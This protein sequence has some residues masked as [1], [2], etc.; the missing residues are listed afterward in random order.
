MNAGAGRY[1]ALSSLSSG[2][3]AGEE[4][5]STRI[6]GNTMRDAVRSK[7]T[8]GKGTVRLPKILVLASGL[9][10]A[11]LGRCSLERVRRLEQELLQAR[12][13]CGAA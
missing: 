11:R 12:E 6:L 1:G 7:E 3:A 8:L 5:A 4:P 2:L 13:G 10:S 9:G